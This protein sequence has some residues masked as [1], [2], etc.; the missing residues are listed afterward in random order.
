MSKN[1]QYF[2][3]PFDLVPATQPPGYTAWFA[4]WSTKPPTLEPGMSPPLVIGV[5]ENELPSGATV[6]GIGSKDPPP[7]PPPIAPGDGTSG[8]PAALVQWLTLSRS[9]DE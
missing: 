7:P 2:S 3:I 8:Y 4:T 1:Y 5:T 6:L 9:A